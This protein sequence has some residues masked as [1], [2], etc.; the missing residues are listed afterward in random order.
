L[1]ISDQK[2][3]SVTAS[4][5]KDNPV[6]KGFAGLSDQVSSV[7]IAPPFLDEDN[8]S[9]KSIQRWDSRIE[10]LVIGLLVIA[11]IYSKITSTVRAGKRF[12]R[13]ILAIFLKIK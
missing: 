7:E 8:N 3:L 5:L 1:A 11:M 6:K 12:F 4:D 10:R 9:V 2:G 13:N